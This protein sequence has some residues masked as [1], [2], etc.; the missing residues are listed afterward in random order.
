MKEDRC[1]INTNKCIMIDHTRKEKQGIVGGNNGSGEGEKACKNRGN[2]H[3]K[4]RHS[5]CKGPE[6]DRNRIYHSAEVSVAEEQ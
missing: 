1:E 2:E 5:M 4:Q 6:V 3:S